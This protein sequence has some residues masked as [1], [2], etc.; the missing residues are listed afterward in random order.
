MDQVTQANAAQTEELTST[1]QAL[2]GQAGELQAL[3][4]RFKLGDGGHAGGTS[5]FRRGPDPAA[6]GRGASGGRWRRARAD[7]T[8]GEVPVR[9]PAGRGLMHEGAGGLLM[10]SGHAARSPR[11]PGAATG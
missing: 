7:A 11:I 8:A 5:R 6:R 4:G 10:A 2:A 3:V 1:A 9:K